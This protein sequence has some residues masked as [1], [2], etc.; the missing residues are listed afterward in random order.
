VAIHTERNQFC[1]VMFSFWL[2]LSQVVHFNPFI[3]IA[4]SATF[5]ISVAHLF[6]YFRPIFSITIEALPIPFSWIGIEMIWKFVEALGSQIRVRAISEFR[7]VY[8]HC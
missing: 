8:L 1:G 2:V 7:A 5:P 6:P 3:A 4:D